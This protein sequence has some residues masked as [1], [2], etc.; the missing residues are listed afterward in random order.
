MEEKT[1]VLS[2]F[3]PPGS[4][5]GTIAHRCEQELGYRMLST[6][7][8]IRGHI[9]EQSDFGKELESYVS[10]GHLVPDD[11]IVQMVLVW[12]KDQVDPGKTIILDGFPRTRGQAD[13][14]LKELSE[15]AAFSHIDFRV[16]NF[17]LSEAEIIKRISSRLVCSNKKCQEVYSTLVKM[18]RNPGI[19]DV[20]DS[21]VLRRADDE[22]NVVR[23]RLNVF[24]AFTT[25][26]L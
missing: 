10:K 18:P 5:K 16:I 11:L 22:A 21:P 2:F 14:L 9:Q 15:N 1:R 4:G 24:S 13:L 23:E 8:L 12:L 6:G 26:L 20:C 3:G 25:L 17:D 19:C 7:D